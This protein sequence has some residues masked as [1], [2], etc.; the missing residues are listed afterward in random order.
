MPTIADIR[1]ANLELLIA[2]AGSLSKLAEKAET[3]S[4][5]LSQV[6]NGTPDIKTARPRELGTTMAR[7]LE[8]A[9][10]KPVGWMDAS[11]WRPAPET[12]PIGVAEPTKQ[13]HV[14][15]DELDLLQRIRKMKARE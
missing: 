13:L 4:V 15:P 10:N 8:V 2:E 5:Y 1:R 7:R 6:R 9:C 3:T 14:T 12:A 11:Q